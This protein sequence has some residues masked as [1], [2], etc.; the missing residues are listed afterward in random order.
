MHWYDDYDDGDA[1]V[2]DKTYDC[3]MMV[4]MVI[5]R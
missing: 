2:S 5:L 3:G 4:V 1:Y